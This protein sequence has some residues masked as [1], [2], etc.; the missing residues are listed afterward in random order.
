MDNTNICLLDK[1]CI[2]CQG[3]VPPLDSKVALNY[4]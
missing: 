2:P 3:G 4:F 1:T